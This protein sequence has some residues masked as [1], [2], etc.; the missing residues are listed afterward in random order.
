MH[1]VKTF[2]IYLYKVIYIKYEIKLGQTQY[3]LNHHITIL[4]KTL[5]IGECYKMY[6]NFVSI[7]YGK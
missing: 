2:C 7:L 4:I 6:C 1:H 5:V 3:S